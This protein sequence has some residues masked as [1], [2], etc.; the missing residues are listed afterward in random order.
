MGP[1]KMATGWTPGRGKPG[2]PGAGR[3]K[4]EGRHLARWTQVLFWPTEG[5]EASKGWVG[6]TCRKE[7]CRNCCALTQGPFRPIQ[8]QLRTPYQSRDGR[9]GYTGQPSSSA[10]FVSYEM[11]SGNRPPDD[12]GLNLS[13]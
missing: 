12:V 10:S 8:S 1:A 3:S 2:K 11:I 7:G 6:G 5:A 4:K 13:N 9:A